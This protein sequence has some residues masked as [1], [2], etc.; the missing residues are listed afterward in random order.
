[1]SLSK[2]Q[3]LFSQNIDMKFINKVTCGWQERIIDSKLRNLIELIEIELTTKKKKIKIQWIISDKGWFMYDVHQF[4]GG[5]LKCD[6]QTIE[7]L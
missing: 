2:S 7:I 3:W 5:R 1:M 4:G 6:N